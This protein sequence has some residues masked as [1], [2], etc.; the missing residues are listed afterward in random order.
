M[1]AIPVILNYAVF[2]IDWGDGHPVTEV[3]GYLIALEPQVLIRL[4]ASRLHPFQFQVCFLASSI[5]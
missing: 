5:F 2:Y 3:S 4:E 1:A